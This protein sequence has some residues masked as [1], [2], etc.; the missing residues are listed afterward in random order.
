MHE[1]IHTVID[2]PNLLTP[3]R[4]A[5]IVDPAARAVSCRVTVVWPL[6]WEDV[7][8]GTPV[9]GSERSGSQYCPIWAWGGAGCQHQR[10]NWVCQLCLYASDAYGRG[11]AGFAEVL[12]AR[13]NQYA[14]EAAAQEQGGQQQ[15]QPQ[16]AKA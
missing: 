14:D 5:G 6:S 16:P 13:A 7:A 11:D 10:P 3:P 1:L 4:S 12:I 15:Q 2:W 8:T 9:A